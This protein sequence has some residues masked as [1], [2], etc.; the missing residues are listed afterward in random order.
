MIVFVALLLVFSTGAGAYESDQYTNRTQDISD[1]RDLLDVEVNHAIRNILARKN[2]PRT[3]G[4][5]AK[6][7]YFE[8]GGLYWADKIERWAAKSPEVEKYDQTRH[9]SVYRGMPFWAT[10]VNFVFGVGRSF[11]VNGVMVGSDKFGHFV[12]QGYKY[13]M[14]ELRGEPPERL[15][16]KGWFAER[17][18]FRIKHCSILRTRPNRARRSWAGRRLLGAGAARV[19]LH[20]I[21]VS[22]E[23]VTPPL[24]PLV[25]M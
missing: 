12:S 16:Q 21:P 18:I 13:Y 7:I 9:E 11:R 24:C 19:R 10:R 20:R 15:L 3:K 8:I 2:A 6:A 4:K 22:A 25:G 5:I 14:R 1:S 17:W 23:R